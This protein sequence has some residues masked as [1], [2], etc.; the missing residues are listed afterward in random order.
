M[1]MF[2]SYRQCDEM[3]RESAL[4]NHEKLQI[5]PVDHKSRHRPE[6]RAQLIG[7]PLHQSCYEEERLSFCNHSEADQTGIMQ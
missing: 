6:V 4:F 1:A 2:K 7:G 3:E 5:G